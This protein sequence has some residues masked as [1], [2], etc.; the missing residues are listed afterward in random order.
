MSKLQLKKELQ[1]LTKEQLIE[2]IFELYDT[3]KPVKEYYQTYLNPQ[4]IEALFEKYKAVIVNEFYPNTISWNP[5]MRFSVAKKAIT[6]FGALKPP[7]KLLTDL[8]ETLVENASRF[9]YD[10]GDMTEQYYNSTVNN[11][12]RALKYLQ[13]AGLLDDFKM[14]CDECLNYAK[15]CGYCFPD[16][17]G[18]LFDEYFQ[19]K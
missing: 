10:Y 19:E 5:K 11:F 1:K 4:N 15:P 3:Y 9:T 6:D 8:L 18:E 12:E 16:E 17:M 7:P 2:Q 14:R 13:K